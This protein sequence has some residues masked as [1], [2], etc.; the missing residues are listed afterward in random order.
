MG[1]M[2]SSSIKYSADYQRGY[3]AEDRFAYEHLDNPVRSTA[4]QDMLEHWDVQGIFNGKPCKFDVK[5]LRKLNR[6]D[7]EFQNDVTWVEGVNVN[8]AKGWLQGHAD[9]IVFERVDEWFVIER[10]FLFDWTTKQLIQHGYK[11]GKDLYS[12][13]QRAGRKDKITLIRYSDI[14]DSHIIKLS[15]L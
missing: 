15:K 13:Y 6:H 8:G 12:I 14:P 1:N 2:Q 10:A 7:K 9:Y 4:E 5:G 11:K 3:E